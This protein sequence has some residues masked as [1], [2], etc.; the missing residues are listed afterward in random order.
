MRARRVHFH[1]KVTVISPVS[2]S[3][4]IAGLASSHRQ[5]RISTIRLSGSGPEEESASDKVESEDD[6]D[7][8]WEFRQQPRRVRKRIQKE[9]NTDIANNEAGGS[10]NGSQSDANNEPTTATQEG[11][12]PRRA[13]S[14]H[15]DPRRHIEGLV[16]ITIGRLDR[17]RNIVKYR[18][19]EI[20]DINDEMIEEKTLPLGEQYPCYEIMYRNEIELV[21]AARNA[22]ITRVKELHKRLDELA[23]KRAAIDESDGLKC[24]IRPMYMGFKRTDEWD[25]LFAY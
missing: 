2:Y 16:N 7:F 15:P 20:S 19:S 5:D 4:N 12:A 3:T 24:T 25:E 22:L 6:L 17:I 18:N 9:M 14:S 10:G 21:R 13:R 11:E 8:D 23:D 1:N